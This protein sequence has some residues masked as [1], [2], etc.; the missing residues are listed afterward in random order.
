MI[1]TKLKKNERLFRF[2][3]RKIQHIKLAKSLS[4]IDNIEKLDKYVVHYRIKIKL[5]E[6]ENYRLGLIIRGKRVWMV[7]CEKRNKFYKDFPWILLQ[8]EMLFMLE[9]K[10]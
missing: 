5:S 9:I 4:A 3:I 8:L 7:R 6:K 2:I 10:K 1:C